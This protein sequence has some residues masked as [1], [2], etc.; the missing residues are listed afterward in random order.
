[1][2]M[3]IEISSIMKKIKANFTKKI[4]HISRKISLLMMITKIAFFLAKFKKITLIT[5][6]TAGKVAIVGKFSY[7]HLLTSHIT[8]AFFPFA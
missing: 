7:F 4:T 2:A 5:I 8:S 3:I 1:M 6:I